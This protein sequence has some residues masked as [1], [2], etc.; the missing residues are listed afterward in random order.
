MENGII[1]LTEEP[2]GSGIL[3]LPLVENG[4]NVEKFELLEEDQLNM[5]E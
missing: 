4:K 3:K 5:F 1:Y 2:P